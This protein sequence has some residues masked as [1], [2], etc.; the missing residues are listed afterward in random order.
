[1]DSFPQLS[2]PKSCKHFFSPPY[3]LYVPPILCSKIRAPELHS[4]KSANNECDYYT[5]FCN[6]LFPPLQSQVSSSLLNFQSACVSFKGSVT[7][8][9]P[10][11]LTGSITVLIQGGAVRADRLCFDNTVQGHENTGSASE[12]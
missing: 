2:V 6:L 3:L 10:C 8:S 12:I 7:V 5:I 1:M 4:M 11:T 9:H